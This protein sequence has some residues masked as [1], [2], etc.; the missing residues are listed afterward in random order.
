[1]ER[2]KDWIGRALL[3][4]PENMNMRYNLACTLCSQL[5][6]IEG[7]L[8]L[9]DAYF[10]TAGLGDVNWAKGDWELD[11]LRGDL[12]FKAMIDAAE[13]RLSDL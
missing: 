9:L 12:R 4:D 7:A 2:A 1:V 5:E 10:A 3:I 6:D 11:P 8:G 13:A